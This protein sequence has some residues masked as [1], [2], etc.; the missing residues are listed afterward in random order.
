MCVCA[1]ALVHMHVRVLQVHACMRVCVQ[2]P[3]RPGRVLDPLELELQEVVTWV[4][5]LE[6]ISSH[7]RP[8]YG[9]LLWVHDESIAL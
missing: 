1:H 4:L 3:Q 7:L 5:G 8:Q 2:C 9:V 6:A